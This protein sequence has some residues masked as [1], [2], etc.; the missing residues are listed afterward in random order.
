M[1]IWLTPLTFLFLFFFHPQCSSYTIMN[2]Y[3]SYTEQLFRPLTKKKLILYEWW[4]FLLHNK[5]TR[6]H[7]NSEITYPIDFY[8]FGQH[9]MVYIFIN[10]SNQSLITL[11]FILQYHKTQTV[12]SIVTQQPFY[13]K[14]IN[15]RNHSM[16][17]MSI[18]LYCYAFDSYKDT[19]PSIPRYNMLL[20][21]KHP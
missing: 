20:E 21:Y 6:V 15:Y 9:H 2:V 14:L 1:S 4:T 17:S 13:A 18:M 16:Q 12:S 7:H 11:V 8:E 19:K 10:M 5:W 3:L